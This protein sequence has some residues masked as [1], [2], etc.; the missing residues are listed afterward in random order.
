MLARGISLAA[1]G[2]TGL[3]GDGNG[4]AGDLAADGAGHQCHTLPHQ[5]KGVAVALDDIHHLRLGLAEHLAGV[6]IQNGLDKMGAVAHAV[7]RQ[8]GGVGS[9]LDGAYHRVALPDSSLNIQRGG[10]VFIRLFGQASQS[11]VYLH[12]GALT[13]TQLVGVGIVDVTGQAASH[14]VEEDVAAPLDGGDHINVAAVAV[15]SAAGVVVLIIGIHTGAVDGGI[16]VDEAAVQRRHRHCRFKGGA[17]GVQALQRPVE[18]GQT[19]VGAVLRIVGGVQVLVKAGVVRSCQHAAVLHI[20]H[21]RSTGGS[22]HIAGIVHPVDHIDVVGKRL[23]HRTLKVAVDGQLHGMPR[24]RYGGDLGVHDH[25]VR[26]AGDGL[27]AILAAQLVLVHGLKAG[28]ADHIVHVIAFFLERIGHLTVFVGHLPLFGGDLT[29]TSQ[30][31][32]EDIPL[33]IAAGAGLHDLHARQREGMLL[34]GSHRHLTDIFRH[35]KV[36]HVGKGLPV[37]LVMDARQHPLPRQ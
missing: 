11:L 1:L 16:L 15:A 22:F 12:A 14:I 25:T 7:I 9:Q 31:S 3:A 26:I 29:H 10:V 13:K 27:H 34:D 4:V 5:L 35:N 28:D 24:L 8:R 23:V 37:H 21:H 36:I 6:G 2:G 33:L 30:H 20:Q 18:Q 32:G 19:G 17:G